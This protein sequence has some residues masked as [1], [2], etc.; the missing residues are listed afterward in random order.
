MKSDAQTTHT[1]ASIKKTA[2]SMND[3]KHQA[4]D[5]RGLLRLAEMYDR[6]RKN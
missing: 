4:A 3:P 1:A 6:T 2:K 5:R